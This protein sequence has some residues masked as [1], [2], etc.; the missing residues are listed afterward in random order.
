MLKAVCP[1]SMI[2]GC[3]TAYIRGWVG[4]VP[5]RAEARVSENGAIKTSC[6]VRE[7]RGHFFDERKESWMDPN[8]REIRMSV[9]SPGVMYRLG[10][11]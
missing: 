4:L 1:K 11:R 5:V 6:R 7:Q 8:I 9:P 2:P 10:N 3:C